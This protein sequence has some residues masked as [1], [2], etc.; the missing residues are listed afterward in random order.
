MHVTYYGK[1]IEELEFDRIFQPFQQTK[2]GMNN[3][4]GGTGLGLAITKQLV[5]L[6][7]G[8]I[9]VGSRL[10]QWTNVS[11]RFPLTVSL[12]HKQKFI[13]KLAD[14][15]V[16]LVSD[17]DLETHYIRNACKHFNVDH[18]HFRILEE[19]NEGMQSSNPGRSFACLVQEE[20]FDDSMYK[21]LSKRAKTILVTFGSAGKIN[22][23]Q[24]H[25]HSL[26]QIF[27]LVLMQEIVSLFDYASLART[28]TPMK[29]KM[30][31]QV[32]LEG[33]KI[34]VAEDNKVNQKVLICLLQR[35]GVVN[36]KVA[37]NGK[38]AV[39]F[40]AAE[41][42]DVVLMDMQMPVMDRL[43]ACKLIVGRS[44]TPPMVV[45]LSVHMAEDF[46]GIC[47]QNGATDILSK[48]TRS[49]LGSLQ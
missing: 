32:S 8:S 39:D 25:Y 44:E 29:R 36:V 31:P 24:V 41:S 23:G 4:D 13:S 1:G 22:R 48:P 33:L 40:K 17:R 27:P 42:F 34:L 16:L 46:K 38:I 49:N 3:V 10:G 26:P 47:V 6:L 7:G 37:D 28:R 21:D 12:V 20:L 45:F 9:S 43:E 19:L 14:C 30:A 5:E 15:C 35:L 11:L 18:L 2:A